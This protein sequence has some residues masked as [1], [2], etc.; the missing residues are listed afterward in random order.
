MSYCRWS[1]NHFECDVYVY[2]HAYG[3]WTTHVA[4]R[5]RK[6]KL[7]DEIKALYPSMDVGPDE[8]GRRMMAYSNAEREWTKSQ[9]HFVVMG[10]DTKRNPIP[11]YFL[12]ASEY[13]PLPA[14]WAGQTYMDP[15][16]GECA[17]RLQVLQ[18]LGF[19]VPDFAIK[20]LMEEEYER[21]H[22]G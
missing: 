22:N 7:P 9:P 1:T 21:T 13:D 6:N 20:A 2:E 8:F 18:G 11:M 17:A 16:P 15:T 5:R 4:G 14:P 3:G 12:A 10:K 19:Q